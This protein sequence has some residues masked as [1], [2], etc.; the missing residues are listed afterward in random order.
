[1][2]QKTKRTEGVVTRSLLLTGNV[3]WIVN[4]RIQFWAVSLGLSPCTGVSVTTWSQFKVVWTRTL[5]YI[6]YVAL[7]LTKK[8]LNI[9]KNIKEWH[10]CP[11]PYK[12]IRD[13]IWKERKTKNKT[14]YPPSL[15]FFLHHTLLHELST[16]QGHADQW[17]SYH[18][19]GWLTVILQYLT[20]AP[21]QLAH[22]II[23]NWKMQ[24]E[25]KNGWLIF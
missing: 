22:N 25:K 17:V 16:V 24:T 5:L 20:T 6:L 18:C 7:A 3:N 23:Q 8:M 9:F 15:F 21:D 14:M 2:E 19:L 13:C 10:Y 12:H 11:K 1:M 4:V